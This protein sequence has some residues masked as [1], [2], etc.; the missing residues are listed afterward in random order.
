MAWCLSLIQWPSIIYFATL[1]RPF[2][3]IKAR[4]YRVRKYQSFYT[5]ALHRSTFAIKVKQ[6]NTLS[7][8]CTYTDLPVTELF[9]SNLRTNTIFKVLTGNLCYYWGWGTF[10][11]Q[12]IPRMFEYYR[13]GN[14]KH[15]IHWFKQIHGHI[16]M[17]LN[18]STEVCSWTIPP[19][20]DEFASRAVLP[21]PG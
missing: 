12:N 6:G 21:F 13:I 20:R 1:P 16:Q 11:I 19:K 15:L 5:V 3:R 2:H 10:L 14:G 4:F 9:M 18:S 17:R 8:R 7:L